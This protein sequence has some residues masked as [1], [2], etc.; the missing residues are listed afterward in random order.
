MIPGN[1]GCKFFGAGTLRCALCLV[2]P[3]AAET[4][5]ARINFR[6]RLGLLSRPRVQLTVNVSTLLSPPLV[7]PTSPEFPLG[8]RTMIFTA[9]DAGITSVESFT[10][11]FVS[12]ST[13]ALRGI[14]FT[15]TSVAETKWLPLTVSVVPDCTSEKVTVLGDKEPISGIGLALP[16]RGLRVLLQPG[17]ARRASNPT[18]D[19]LATDRPQLRN[20]MGD[21]PFEWI[22]RL[23]LQGLSTGSN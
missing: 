17:R 3:G 9:P 22:A 15:T 23:F 7:Q 20:D 10:V 18:N 6:E 16:Q 2:C 13:V 11:N 12:L 21:T 1:I 5:G 8:V 19:R 14:E 4:P